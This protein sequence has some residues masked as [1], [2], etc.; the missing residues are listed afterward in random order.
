MWIEIANYSPNDLNCDEMLI[1]EILGQWK[2]FEHFFF[3]KIF[4]HINQQH[5]Y[6][7][8]K[9]FS[10]GFCNLPS[11]FLNLII[12]LLKNYSKI[13]IDSGFW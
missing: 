5:Y 13:R 8:I 4:F 1:I 9:I 7:V 3:D 2:H 12:N 10:L 11:I 6:L